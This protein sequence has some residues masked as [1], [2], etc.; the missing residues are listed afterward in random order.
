MLDWFCRISDAI[1]QFLSLSPFW[2]Q[3]LLLVVVVVPTCSVLAIVLLRLVDIFGALWLRTST[4]L[5]AK[6]VKPRH[7]TGVREVKPHDG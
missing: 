2:L 6:L 5:R 1:G 3:V 4:A 7:P